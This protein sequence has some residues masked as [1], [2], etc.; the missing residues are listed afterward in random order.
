LTF[1]KGQVFFQL[2]FKSD[3]WQTNTCEV[4]FDLEGHKC[5]K[6]L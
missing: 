6:V 2:T 1:R 4:V 5:F 3:S